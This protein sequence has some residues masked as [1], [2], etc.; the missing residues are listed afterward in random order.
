[1]SHSDNLRDVKEKALER[2]LLGTALATLAGYLALAFA[3]LQRG[4]PRK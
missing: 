3:V 2:I 1:M 4:K